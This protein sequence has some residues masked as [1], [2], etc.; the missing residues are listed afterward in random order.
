MAKTVDVVT[1]DRTRD[2]MPALRRWA[3][4]AVIDA[5]PIT[6]AQLIA[7]V[8]AAVA[9]FFVS[10]IV[11]WAATIFGAR[12]IPAPPGMYSNT[13]PPAALAPFYH[14]DTDAY[15]YIA[16]HG[17][18]LGSGGVEAQAIRVAWFPFYPLLV[19]L[20]G[21]SVWAMILV[22]NVCFLASLALLHVVATRR[23]DA[24]RA[25]L[26]LWLVAIGPAAMFFSYP[27]TESVFLLLCVGAFALMESGHWLMAGLAGMAA[28]GTRFPGVLLAASFGAE[29]VLNKRRRLTIAVAGLLPVA[30]LAVVSLVDWTQMGDPL[31]FVH[32]RAFWI[33]P[34][35][36]PLYL[37]GSFPKAVIEGDP[38]NPEAIGVP[39][40]AVFAIGAA[41]VA[42]RMPA[43]YGVF[44]VT[45]VLV[46]FDQG[47]YLHIFSL[48]PRV[49]SVIF[50]CYFAFATLLAT[51][52]N[53][54]LAWI[55]LS[56]SAM[57]F[58]AALYGAWRFVG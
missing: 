58:N 35:R 41:W 55:G 17:Y 13:Y 27:Y 14:W 7:G 18:T 22:P 46:A 45:Q 37:V 16:H 54:R 47:L 32:A 34:D 50:P 8:Q 9:P 29:S 30:G 21:G 12:N 44:A 51:R 38:F 15:W 31:G 19:Y 25:Q 24:E 56:A 36:N 33:G 49:V 52:R 39:V 40:L 57:I 11:V 6:R 28:A 20:S 53:L 3:G 5:A 2:R 4:A 48:V 23:M 43:A 10:R 42:L 26:A 1:G